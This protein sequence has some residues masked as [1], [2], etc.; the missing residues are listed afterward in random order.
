MVKEFMR[1]KSVNTSI[2]IF[3]ESKILPEYKP[4]IIKFRSLIK[5]KFPNIKEEMRGGTKQ[6][7]GVPVY[8]HIRIILTLSPTKKGI[9]FSFSDGKRFEDKYNALE[10]KGNTSLNLRIGKLEEYGDDILEYYIKQAIKFDQDKE[11]IKIK[12]IHSSQ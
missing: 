11:K 7:Y 4:I 10:G 6:Y 3:I 1:E 9:T 5:K 8:R 12:K 2:D